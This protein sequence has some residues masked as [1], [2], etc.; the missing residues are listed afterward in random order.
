MIS[1]RMAWIPPSLGLALLCLWLPDLRS[2]PAG[3]AGPIVVEQRWKSEAKP[4]LE[5]Y[6]Y[7]CHGDGLDKGELDFDDFESIEDM[8]ADRGRWKRIRGHLDQQL[9]PPPDEVQPTRAERDTLIRWIDD[10]I[11]PVDPN[12]PDPGRV[13]LRRLNRIEYQNTI[14]DLLGVKVKVQDL[15]PPD[16]SG[17]GFDNIGDVLTL[18]PLHLER[19]LEAARVSLDR[20]VHPGPMPFPQR[21]IAGKDLDGPGQR[22]GDGH[23][24]LSNGAA[25]TRHRFAKPGT[26]RIVVGAAGT[27]GGEDFPRMRLTVG[28][29]LEQEWEIRAAI[30]KPQQCVVELKIEQAVE[31]PLAA[32]FLN[33]FWDPAHPTHK[34]RNLLVRSITIEGPL[35]GPR[36]PK[37][38]SHRALYGERPEGASEE[39]WARQIFERFARRAFRRPPEPGEA[40]RYLHFVRLAREQQQSAELGI[41]HG[42]E[43]M[44][45]SPSFLFREEPQPEP[46][47]AERSHRIGEHALASRLSYFLWST[48][49]DEELMTLADDGKLREQLDAQLE[50]MLNSPK[51]ERLVLHFTGQWLQLRDLQARNLHS[52]S[53]PKFRHKLRDAMQRETEQLFAH[54]IADNRPLRELLDADYTF[55][56]E[57]LAAHYGIQGVKGGEFRKVS[58]EGTPRRGLLGHG[59]FHLITSHPTRTS[60]VLRGKYVLENLLNQ[61]PPP[62]PPNVAQ[63]APT[64]KETRGMTLREQMELHRDKPDCRSCHALMDPIGFGLENFD[65]DGSYRS[66]AN[67]KPVDASGKL[68][69]GRE[70]EGADELRAILIQHHR[71]DFHR[72]VAS[73]ML[74]YAIGRGVDWYDKPALDQIVRD[75]E[76]AGGGARDLIR[77]V[78]HSV[79]FQMRRGEG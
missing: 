17:Y 59:S 28:D 21:R 78:I 41:R 77:A 11:F 37:P 74:S 66:E 6:C 60:P 50:R 14:E 35:E 46:D 53:Y 42:L 24:L 2:E 58:L 20:A 40:E 79:P 23:Y 49:P 15:L 38:R 26:Y 64:S 3:T 31:L 13:T 44:L 18:S 8:I 72:A 62:P 47:N 51:A 7:D 36:Q 56:D 48:M 29:V 30:D 65:A 22:G 9:M 5:N 61:A 68:A 54:L 52:K 34:D 16:D 75:T 45:V 25:A 19:F 73:K 43:A 27:K 4:I 10:A 55:V 12:H 32:A 57:R 63:L 33:D 39:E 76:A 1:Y 69:S 71:S 67:G 70:F